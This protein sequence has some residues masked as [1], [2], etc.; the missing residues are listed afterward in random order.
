M[1]GEHLTQQIGKERRQDDAAGT[2]VLRIDLGRLAVDVLVLR[3]H[4]DPAPLPLILKDEMV[5]AQADDLGDAQPAIGDRQD[6][7]VADNAAHLLGV[8]GQQ[9]SLARGGEDGL[10]FALLALV[11]AAPPRLERGHRVVAAD[12][13]GDGIVEHD[14]H[15]RHDALHVPG[16]VVGAQLLLPRLD[17][18][19][20][21]VGHR[22]VLPAG[23]DHGSQTLPVRL[24]AAIGQ[25]HG[26]DPQLRPLSDGDAAVSRIE[27]RLAANVRL[28]A[29]RILLSVAFLA[30]G[31]LVV[32]PGNGS[33]RAVRLQIAATPALLA[34]PVLAAVFGIR[35]GS[36]RVAQLLGSAERAPA[37]G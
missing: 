19:L 5:A 15:H 35:H 18:H 12:L 37:W 25:L 34:V 9:Q 23:E 29:F 16:L 11:L 21:H 24:V 28:K 27:E 6:E 26:L 30:E 17:G 32:V 2:P 22:N 4:E 33:P 36:P 3:L 10:V 20:G 1:G 13:G 31:L 8:A 14:P 7:G